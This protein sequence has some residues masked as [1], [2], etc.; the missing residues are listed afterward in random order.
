MIGLSIS[1]FS[2]NMSHI[3]FEKHPVLQTEEA[4][5]DSTQTLHKIMRKRQIFIRN[6]LQGEYFCQNG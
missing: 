4:S 3:L 1:T 2:P 6:Y 5:L